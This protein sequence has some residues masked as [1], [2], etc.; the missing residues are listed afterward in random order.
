MDALKEHEPLMSFTCYEAFLAEEGTELA[1]IFVH[2]TLS[3]A[4]GMESFHKRWK[5]LVEMPDDLF[6]KKKDSKSHALAKALLDYAKKC[7]EAKP[8]LV[9]IETEDIKILEE[10]LMTSSVPN[11]LEGLETDD[12]H[13][14]KP[15]Q[16][17]APTPK[18][19]KSAP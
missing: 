10:A 12:K 17:N 11:G 9:D 3:G 8:R 15:S 1:H 7:H 14:D 4:V 16:P 18:K 19:Q 13:H 6:E 2:E 5:F